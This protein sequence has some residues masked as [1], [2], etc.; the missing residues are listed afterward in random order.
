MTTF[1][2]LETIAWSYQLE[3]SKA[4][5]L[6]ATSWYDLHY[7]HINNTIGASLVAQWEKKKIQLTM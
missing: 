5:L 2:C 1:H 6:M 7:D 3:R 4:G